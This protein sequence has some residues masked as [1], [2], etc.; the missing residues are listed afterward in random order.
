MIQVK[1]QMYEHTFKATVDE[2]S[3]PERKNVAVDELLTSLAQ[4]LDD[5]RGG[6]TCSANYRFRRHCSHKFR[7]AIR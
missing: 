3:N 4:W 2:N 1:F 5:V 7:S 6:L